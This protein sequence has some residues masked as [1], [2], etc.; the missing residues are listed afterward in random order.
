MRPTSDD[1][2][3]AAHRTTLLPNAWADEIERCRGEVARD[4]EEVGGEV[5]HRQVVERTC[6][7]SDTA[8]VEQGDA[9][10]AAEH[11]RERGFEVASPSTEPD[12]KRRADL[13]R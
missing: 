1:A 5:V 4:S 8:R 10:P 12:D 11:A 9:T 6:A 3:A 13:H 2:S 7:L